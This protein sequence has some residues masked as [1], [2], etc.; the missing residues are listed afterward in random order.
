VLTS[1]L[2]G[3]FVWL[4]TVLW[5]GSDCGHCMVYDCLVVRA[6]LWSLVSGECLLLQPTCCCFCILA[7]GDSQSLRPDF[8]SLFKKNMMNIDIGT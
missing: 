3:C 1:L 4:L 2:S 8:V 7:V 5:L 6:G